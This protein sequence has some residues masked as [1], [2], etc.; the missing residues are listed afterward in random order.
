MLEYNDM[1]MTILKFIAIFF[2]FIIIPRVIFG[3]LLFGAYLK[4]TLGIFIG[5]QNMTDPA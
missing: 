2:S 5:L 1:L 4:A 3:L